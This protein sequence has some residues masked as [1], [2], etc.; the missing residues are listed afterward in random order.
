MKQGWETKKLDEVLV[1]TETFDPTK[2]PNVEFKYLDV[3]SVNL[4]FKL[5]VQLFYLEKMHQAEQEN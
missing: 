5:E 1:K 2:K 4:R 3:S